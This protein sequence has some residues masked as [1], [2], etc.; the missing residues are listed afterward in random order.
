MESPLFRVKKT[1]FTA[2]LRRSG[3]KNRV[4]LFFLDE[5][6]WQ[7]D[8]C[9]WNSYQKYCRPINKIKVEEKSSLMAITI[10]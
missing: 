8:R 2:D 1:N 3:M 5:S 10:K 7:R 4:E 9:G 6:V